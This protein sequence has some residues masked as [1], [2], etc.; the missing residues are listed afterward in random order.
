VPICDLVASPVM[1]RQRPMR[2]H[3]LQRGRG[4]GRAAAAPEPP[5]KKSHR[6]RWIVLALA[7]VVAVCVGLVVGYKMIRSNYYVGADDGSVVIL[8]GLPGSILGYSIHDVNL[9]GC[10]TRNGELTLT[11][12][13]ENVPS[14]CKPLKVT[15]LKQTGRDQVDKGL[16]PGSLDKARDSMT[17]LAQR[18]LLPPCAVKESAPQPGVVPSPAETAAPAPNGAPPAPATAAPAPAPAPEQGD[19]RGTEIKTPTTST[20]AAPTSTSPAP[21]TAGENCRVTD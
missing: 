17:Y 8:R 16:P 7:L 14:A 2:L 4:S 19:A 12:P 6:L 20:P 5:A 1:A 9:V 11:E 3:R 18:E 15:D 13:G 21:Q 10:V